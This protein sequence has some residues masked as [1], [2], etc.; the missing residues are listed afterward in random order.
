M[1]GEINNLRDSLRT[2]VVPGALASIPDVWF[3]VGRFEDCSY[4]T[5]NMAVLQAMTSDVVAVETALTGW[6]TCG[7]SEPYTQ[8]LYALAS[9]D[10]TPFLGWGGVT[11]TSWTCT[12]PGDIGWPCFRTG[13]MPIIVQFGDEDFSGATSYCSPGYNHDQAITAMNAV[14][15]RYIGVNS[16]TGTYSSHA[17]MVIIATGTGSVDTTGSPLVFDISS[18]GTGLGSQVVEAIEILAEQVPIEVTTDVRDDVTDLVD[19]EDRFIDYIEASVVGGWPDPTDPTI[20]CVSGLAVDDLYDPFDGRPDTFTSVLPGTP[21]CF[22]IYVKLNDTVPCT[23][24]PQT[25]LCEIDVVGD[26]I[27]VLSTRN[28]YFLVPPCFYGELL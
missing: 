1:S 12:P 19:T 14:S 10:I 6:S 4:C 18:T 16:G 17:D 25:Y 23:E 22:D 13:S 5:Y 20:L 9:G 28:V 7:G 15:A 24:E 8:D 27:T 3:G 26:G 21:V 2:T 11:P